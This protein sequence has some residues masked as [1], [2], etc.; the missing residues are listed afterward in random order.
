MSST[1]PFIA[2]FVMEHDRG[3]SI[4]PSKPKYSTRMESSIEEDGTR[5]IESR[6]NNYEGTG[7]TFTKAKV[8]PTNDEPEDR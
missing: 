1:I 5:S 8:D 4:S 2:K 6:L 7:S 3:L